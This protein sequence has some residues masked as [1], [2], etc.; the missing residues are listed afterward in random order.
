[1]PPGTGTLPPTRL[2]P[3][4]R[5]VTG[6]PCAWQARITALTSAVLRTRTTASGTTGVTSL[7]SDA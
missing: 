2:V 3:P 4:E 7:A 6:T 5:G 1:M